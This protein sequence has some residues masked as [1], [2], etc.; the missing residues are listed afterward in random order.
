M[1]LKVWHWVHWSTSMKIGWCWI[2]MPPVHSELSFFTGCNRYWAASGVLIIALATGIGLVT[3][4]SKLVSYWLVKRTF[5]SREFH[6]MKGSVQQAAA[7]GCSPGVG[8]PAALSATLGWQMCINAQINST[9]GCQKIQQGGEFKSLRDGD[10][11]SLPNI[12]SRT[13][14]YCCGHKTSSLFKKYSLIYGLI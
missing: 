14:F 13:L 8:E 2:L 10:S 9:F 5:Q 6:L 3:A 12:R 4:E 7:R 11:P 1:S